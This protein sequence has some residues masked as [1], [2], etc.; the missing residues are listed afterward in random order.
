[1]E[2]SPNHLTEWHLLYGARNKPHSLICSSTCDYYTCTIIFTF[3]N[4][5]SSTGEPVDV[6][7]VIIVTLYVCKCTCI[8]E[9][10]RIIAHSYVTAC[11]SGV[12]LVGIWNFHYQKSLWL[13]RTMKLNTVYIFPAVCE[14]GLAG[15]LCVW[16]CVR[17]NSWV[18]WAS[19][20]IRR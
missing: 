5:R 20:G 4:V 6:E 8:C 3:R 14:N 12:V 1:M 13:A 7:H 11:E 9:F 19:K 10:H 16:V 2:Q 18:H 15:T 17:M